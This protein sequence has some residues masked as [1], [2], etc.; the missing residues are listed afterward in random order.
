MSEPLTI[1]IND[2]RKLVA[3]EVKIC[4]DVTDNDGNIVMAGAVVTVPEGVVAD[5]GIS[6]PAPI[7][8]RV[9][10]TPTQG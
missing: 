2:T 9:Y 10:S 4:G 8:A 5:L 7:A 6:N 3:R 1:T